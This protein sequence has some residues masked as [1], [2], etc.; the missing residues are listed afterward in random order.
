MYSEVTVHLGID[1]DM[2]VQHKREQLA[3][4][5]AEN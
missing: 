1:L 2:L 5:P 4:C 3:I